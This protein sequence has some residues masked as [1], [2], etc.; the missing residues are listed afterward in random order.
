M[1]FQYLSSTITIYVV[2]S[3]YITQLAAA[4]APLLHDP[5]T[6]ITDQEFNATYTHLVGF[7]GCGMLLQRDIV[8]A[9]WDSAAILNRNNIR[10]SQPGD[11]G[12]D[13]NLPA[14]VEYLGSPF[15]SPYRGTIQS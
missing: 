14:A 9:F 10:N 2:F 4:Q 6:P 12:I 11:T 15:N 5:G 1:F 7:E 3:Q 13:W 8:Q